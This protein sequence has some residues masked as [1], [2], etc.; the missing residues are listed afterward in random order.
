MAEIYVWVRASKAS[1][2]YSTATYVN[3]EATTFFL[4][5]V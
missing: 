2:S 3:A 1:L 5:N 4:A